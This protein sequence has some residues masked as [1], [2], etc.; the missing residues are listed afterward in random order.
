MVLYY[1]GADNIAENMSSKYVPR[2]FKQNLIN[3]QI[4]RL[5]INKVSN[6]MA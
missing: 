5:T 3:K 2:D 1:R 6:L 4:K